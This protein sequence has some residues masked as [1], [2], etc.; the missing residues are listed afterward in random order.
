MGL[1]W[2]QWS[3]ECI[4]IWLGYLG[5]V[6]GSCALRG[7]LQS[8][9]LEGGRKMVCLALSDAVWS[10]VG[11]GS[12]AGWLPSCRPC[13]SV[14]QIHS[15]S[16]SLKFTAIFVWL[17]KEQRKRFIQCAKSELQPWGKGGTPHSFWQALKSVLFKDNQFQGLLLSQWSFPS[18]PD[19]VRALCQS[20]LN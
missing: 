7:W 8:L 1:F 18:S 12:G 17:A 19:M 13:S 14:P 10:C 4:H 15:F 6:M 3:V 16:L 5:V 9:A 2:L 20:F 11:S